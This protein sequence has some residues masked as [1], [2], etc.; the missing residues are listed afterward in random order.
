MAFVLF[1]KGLTQQ[2]SKQTHST[3]FPIVFGKSHL[4][5]ASTSNKYKENKTQ[6]RVAVNY[7][8]EQQRITLRVRFYI[9]AT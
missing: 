2:P 3:G 1:N 7:H 9:Q 5:R 6:S 8:S 4:H